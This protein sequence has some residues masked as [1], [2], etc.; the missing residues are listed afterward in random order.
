MIKLVR[1]SVAFVVNY[2]IVEQTVKNLLRYIFAINP[3]NPSGYFMYRH[4]ELSTYDVTFRRVRVTTVA[5]KEQYY[6]F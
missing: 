4:F 3:L 2:A 6:V 5:V 1:R